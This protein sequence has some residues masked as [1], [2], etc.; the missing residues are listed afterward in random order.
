[1]A[2][3][4]PTPGR[5]R[6]FLGVA[7]V[8]YKESIGRFV[9]RKPGVIRR[10]KKVLKINEKVEANPP[11]ARAK[12]ACLKDHPEFGEHCPI[13][14]FRKYLKNEMKAVVGK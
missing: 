4:G 7:R 5:V 6:N 2:E 13:Q 11:A 1:M 14:Y 3:L 8:Y 9:I 10:S 12:A